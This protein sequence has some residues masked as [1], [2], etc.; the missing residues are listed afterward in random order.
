ME[1]CRFS[2]PKSGKPSNYGGRGR[3]AT[4][5]IMNKQKERNWHGSPGTGVE[6]EPNERR[7]ESEASGVNSEKCPF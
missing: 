4:G 7:E 2:A 1:T 5:K 6:Q 3:G